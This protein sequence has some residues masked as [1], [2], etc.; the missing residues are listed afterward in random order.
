MNNLWTVFHD[1]DTEAT[2]NDL[3]YGITRLRVGI[4]PR[5][6]LLYLRTVYPTDAGTCD[7][8]PNIIYTVNEHDDTLIPGEASCPLIVALGKVSMSI[9]ISKFKVLS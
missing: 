8:T 5:D 6:I 7:F 2:P 3:L 1:P 9:G 4:L